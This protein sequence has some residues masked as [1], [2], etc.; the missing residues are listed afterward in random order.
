MATE[1]GYAN[2]TWA[3]WRELI[4][5]YPDDLFILA[6]PSNQYGE[7]EPY[8]NSELEEVM[9]EKG[10]YDKELMENNVAVLEKSAVAGKG[11]HPMIHWLTQTCYGDESNFGVDVQWNYEKWILVSLVKV[12]LHYTT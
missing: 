10:L 4:R 7:L 11:G 5:E 8:K 6:Q 1:C 3:E 12:V 9:T 2:Q